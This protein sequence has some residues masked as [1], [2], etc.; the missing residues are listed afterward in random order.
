MR[1]REREVVAHRYL[2]LDGEGEELE[3]RAKEGRG[4]EKNLRH[5]RGGWGGREELL[6]S[7]PTRADPR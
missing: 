3:N 2:K 7:N 6:S 1:G 4:I 5:L